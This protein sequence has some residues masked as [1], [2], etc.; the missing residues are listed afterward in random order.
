MNFR[1]IQ[2]PISRGWLGTPK[3]IYLASGS[4]G[5]FIDHYFFAFLRVSY[6]VPTRLILFGISFFFAVPAVTRLTLFDM[7]R[8][9]NFFFLIIFSSYKFNIAIHIKQH[10]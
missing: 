1:L 10:Y 4:G 6:P 8:V 5:S 7:L 9:S 2:F 3:V